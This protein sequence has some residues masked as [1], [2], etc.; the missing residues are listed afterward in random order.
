[1]N[2]NQLRELADA[3]DKLYRMETYINGLSQEINPG[4]YGISINWC[5]GAALPGYKDTAVA[6]ATHLGLHLPGL[7]KQ[8]LL[9]HRKHVDELEDQ[10]RRDMEFL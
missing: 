9:E 2:S 3:K 4:V 6:V 1:M 7:F 5:L 10:L 8:V